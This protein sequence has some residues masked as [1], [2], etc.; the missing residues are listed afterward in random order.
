MNRAQP[1]NTRTGEL[2]PVFSFT[3]FAELWVMFT[4]ER[5]SEWQIS[6]LPPKVVQS[7]FALA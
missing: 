3:G 1:I 2:G 5:P 7:A 6:L 4:Q